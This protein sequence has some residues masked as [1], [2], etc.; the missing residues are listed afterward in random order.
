[1]THC[2][3]S[4]VCTLLLLGL[5]AA[6]CADCVLC[7]QMAGTRV[8]SVSVV[9]HSADMAG[10][11]KL[12]GSLIGSTVWLEDSDTRVVWITMLALADA[13][14]IVGASV[15][16]LAKLAGVPREACEYALDKFLSPDPDSRSKEHEGRRIQEVDGGWHLLNYAKYREKRDADVRREQ[17]KQAMRRRRAKQP[18]DAWDKTLELN[19]RAGWDKP[20]T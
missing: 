12:F 15:P 1:M 16:G 19:G 14:G 17:N 11:T 13:N 5:T 8:D 9:A 3:T 2:V 7:V 6:H 18:S 20:T 10:F 4:I